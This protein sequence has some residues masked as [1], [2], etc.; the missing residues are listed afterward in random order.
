VKVLAI[1]AHPDD[2]ELGCGGLLTKAARAGHGVYMCTVTRGSASGDPKERTDEL[3][4]SAKYIG[5]QGVRIGDFEDT[6]LRVDNDLINFIESY[7]DEV[8]P[9]LILTHFHGDIHHDHRAVATATQEAGRFDSN[10]LAYEIPLTRNFDPKVYYDIS[11]VIDDKIELIRIYW[12][13]RSKLYTKA[14][15][16]KSLAEFRALQSRLNT[17]V[18]YVEAFDAM[19]LCIDKDFRLKRVPYE[20]QR[21]SARIE[22]LQELQTT[23][24]PRAREG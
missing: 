24:I 12:S 15:A 10:M 8:E 17:K 22:A 14:N 13:Q 7:V 6:K 21:S 2:I 19:K 18:N 3:F 16:I 9:D 5:A 20:K 1:G 11:D 4:K 23:V